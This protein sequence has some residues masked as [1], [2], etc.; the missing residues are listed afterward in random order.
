MFFHAKP[1]VRMKHSQYIGGKESWKVWD[2]GS[3]D[4]GETS[5]GTILKSLSGDDAKV[6][7][8]LQKFSYQERF[9]GM[10]IRGNYVFIFA[11]KWPGKHKQLAPQRGRA[12]W[13][14]ESSETSSRGLSW[15]SQFSVVVCIL[16]WIHESLGPEKG[17]S[18][19]DM[20][21]EGEIAYGSYSRLPQTSPMC[22]VRGLC[23]K[24]PHLPLHRSEKV[25]CWI[26]EFLTP[27]ESMFPSRIVSVFLRCKTTRI[28]FKTFT[29]ILSLRVVIL[30]KEKEKKETN[31]T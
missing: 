15:E 14:Q 16:N 21:K 20:R 3:V 7:K 11:E 12:A 9:K 18:P 6:K 1:C 10:H 28:S 22:C 30:K 13:G 8:G 2:N 29:R 31:I 26:T 25:P 24:H 17:I 23:R 4:K 19:R 27:S 5:S